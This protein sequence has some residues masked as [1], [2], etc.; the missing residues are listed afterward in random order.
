M[1]VHDSAALTR[2]VSEG[3][4]RLRVGLENPARCLHCPA[5]PDIYPEEKRQRSC[6]ILLAARKRLSMIVAS[7]GL[8][9]VGIDWFVRRGLHPVTVSLPFPRFFVGRSTSVAANR[10]ERF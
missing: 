2:G 6:K 7:L 8:S 3:V 1:S 5:H 10:G 9:E 4:P